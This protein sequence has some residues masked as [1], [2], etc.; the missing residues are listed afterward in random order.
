MT[1]DPVF[2]N[3]VFAK[4]FTVFVEVVG[5]NEPPDSLP[6]IRLA[7]QTAITYWTSV[8]LKR[9]ASLPDSLRD[10]V[11]SIL[12]TSKSYSMLV[13]PQVV[14]TR[15]PES[16][17]M[18]IK[19]MRERS[20]VFE[21]RRQYLAKAQLEG[22]TVLINAVDFQ[23]DL[24]T[25]KPP[26]VAAGKIDLVTVL[27]HE[28]GHCFGLPDLSGANIP[29]VMNPDNLASEPTEVDEVAFVEALAKNVH[30]SVPGEFNAA[31]CQ[32]LRYTGKSA[33]GDKGRGGAPE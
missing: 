28:L 22:R 30:G 12:P 18:V 10:Y 2:N 6:D 14:Q 25:P 9:R 27:I 20:N 16:A 31:L 5:G 21:G 19:W 15:C 26:I 33:R 32:G 13:P 23:F 29:S 17:T 24:L 4:G 7:A 11:T 3:D 1:L 8:L